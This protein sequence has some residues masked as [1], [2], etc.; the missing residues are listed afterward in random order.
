MN[1]P[2]Q[3]TEVASELHVDGRSWFCIDLLSVFDF[4]VILVKN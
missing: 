2:H 1:G 3:D 4:I